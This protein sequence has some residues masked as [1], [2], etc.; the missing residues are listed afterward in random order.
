GP[1]G[2]RGFASALDAD[3][4]GEEGKFYVWRKSEIDALLGADAASFDAAYDVTPEGNWEGH[5]IL[6]R[7]A[8]PVL[9]SAAE[10]AR[11][12]ACRERLLA[13]RAG[14]VRPGWDDKVLADWNGLM[15]AALAQ[16]AT[17]SGEPAWLEAAREAFA[18]VT[19]AMTRE[20]RLAHSWRL[21]QARHPATLDD[22]ANLSRAALQLH[23][24]TGEP[25]Y[26][27]QAEAWA[28]KLDRHYRDRA[29]GGHFLIAHHPPGG[30]P[31]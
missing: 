28:A 14:R 17:V 2:T 21:G 29:A 6:N 19:S 11:L 31:R 7:S 20:G 12:A 26:L 24:A 22:Y 9:G 3:S 8:R 18:F 30:V 16:A 15:S 10:E 23:A 1:H 25:A 27:A 4:E 13:L 5:T